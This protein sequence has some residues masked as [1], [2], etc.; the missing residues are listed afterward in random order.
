MTVWLLQKG[1]PES[2]E[3]GRAGRGSDKEQKVGRHADAGSRLWA[4]T[5]GRHLLVV[6]GPDDGHD[7]PGLQAGAVRGRGGGLQRDPDGT[8]PGPDPWRAYLLDAD[9]WFRT[10]QN[11]QSEFFSMG[12]TAVLS[13]YLRGTR[14][15]REQTRREDLLEKRHRGVS[16]PQYRSTVDSLA[17]QPTGVGTG[18][19]H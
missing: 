3:L 13:I 12:S 18:R 1:S 17:S 9:L 2:E 11:W 15:T 6:T 10:L 16:A 8:A 19:K 7:V 4:R 5:G 14:L